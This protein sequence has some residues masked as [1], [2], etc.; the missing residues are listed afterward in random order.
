MYCIHCTVWSITSR[1]EV[2]ESVVIEAHWQLRLP[3]RSLDC[4]NISAALVSG[5][6]GGGMS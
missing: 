4:P 2:S 3:L 6:T 5:M 1:G